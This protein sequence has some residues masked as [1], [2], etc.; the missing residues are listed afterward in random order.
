MTLTN[1][2]Q[3]YLRGLAHSFKPVVTVGSAGLTDAVINETD[4]VLET[5]ELIKARVN[6]DNKADRIDIANKIINQTGAVLVQII[7]H[8]VI[9]Y[10]PKKKDP[11]ISLPKQ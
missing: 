7:G 1:K 11:Q 5:H 10:R 9:L 3:R 2:Q 4:A 8:I 6:A